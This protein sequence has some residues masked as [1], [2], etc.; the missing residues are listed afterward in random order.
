MEN[1]LTA[2]YSIAISVASLAVFQLLAVA[3]Y[4]FK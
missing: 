1:E 2:L 4:R 3:G